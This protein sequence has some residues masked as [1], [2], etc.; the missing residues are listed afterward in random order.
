MVENVYWNTGASTYSASASTVYTNEKNTQTVQGRI[1]LMA[2]SDYG[3]AA[4][5]GRGNLSAY[6]T[7]N[8]T[9]SNWLFGKGDE[10]TNIQYSSPTTNAMRVSNT[11]SVV[12]DGHD[13]G[14]ARNGY[15]VRPVLYLSA[16]VYVVSGDGS[17]ANPYQI[18]M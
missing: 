15:A 6:D 13:A 7:A 1:G 5:Y 11:L 4:S 18:A 16:S 14:Q 8:Y 17:E 10:W 3:Y 12:Y 9:G 2:A